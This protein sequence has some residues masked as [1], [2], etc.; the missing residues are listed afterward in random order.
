MH[1]T[2]IDDP[3][4]THDMHYTTIDSPKVKDLN[5]RPCTM[6]PLIDE[7]EKTKIRTQ[8]CTTIDNLH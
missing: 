8:P 1:Y 3:E 5:P 2:T 4:K 7:P 6:P